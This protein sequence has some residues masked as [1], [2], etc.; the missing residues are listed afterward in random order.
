MGRLQK[1]LAKRMF[2]FLWV[3]ILTYSAYAISQQ[4]DQPMSNKNY[5]NAD[6][7]SG[8]WGAICQIKGEWVCNTIAGKNLF[9]YEAVEVDLTE[10]P[11]AT[12]FYVRRARRIYK[13]SIDGQTVFYS[14]AEV[15]NGITMVWSNSPLFKIY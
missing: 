14:Y 4:D 7:P 12:D 9:D 15:S 1:L 10:L 5:V 8:Q 2:D 6:N 11:D 3:F 13:T